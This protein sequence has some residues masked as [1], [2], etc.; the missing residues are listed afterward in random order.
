MNKPAPNF[1]YQAFNQPVIKA[2]HLSK[3][4]QQGHINVSVLNSID[5]TVS[6]GEKLAVVGRSGSGKSTLL[7]LLGGL[8]S[9]TNGDIDLLG[10]PLN[11]T[12]ANQ[13]AKIRNT[14]FGFVYQFH[15]LLAELSAVENVAVPLLFQPVKIDKVQKY[16][17]KLL[18][19]VGL[20]KRMSHK[21]AELSGGERQ[22]VAIARALIN[23]PACVLADEPTGNLDDDNAAVVLDLID[24][25]S[26]QLGTSFVI[27]THSWP[28]ANKMDRVIHLQNGCIL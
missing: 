9:P 12:S 25:L 15:H 23:D 7:H 1:Q 26:S 16:A 18:A 21:P 2:R 11:Q 6:K 19:E 17:A 8:D 22:R 27:A 14:H 28:L 24:R 10:Q 4:Y 5:L 3:R 20:A 13:R